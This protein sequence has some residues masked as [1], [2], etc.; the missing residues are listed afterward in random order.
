MLKTLICLCWLSFAGSALG[1]ERPYLISG[2]DDVLRQAENT[3]LVK[4]ALKILEA[5]KGYSG[6]PELYQVVTQQ[7][8]KPHFSLVS[9]ISHWFDRRIESFLHNSRYPEH[10]RML[11]NWLTEWSIE[12]FKIAK[13]SEIIAKHGDRK[14]IVI[15]DNSDASLGLAKALKTRFKD[16]I[17]AIYLRQVVAKETP[18][19]AQSFFTAFEIA[20]SEFIHDRLSLE[21]LTKVAESILKEEERA[22]LFPTYA[23]CP[24]DYRPCPTPHKDIVKLCLSVQSH[25]LS[26]CR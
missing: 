18:A 22:A 10:E 26:L 2:F 15:F 6:M 25:V 4:A 24:R 12:S 9:A 5:D 17:V 13:I 14:F 21:D 23:L 19:E 11:R 3:G 8:G 20:V 7:E 1:V 16:R